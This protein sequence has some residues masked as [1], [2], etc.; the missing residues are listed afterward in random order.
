MNHTLQLLL[1]LNHGFDPP[2]QSPKQAEPDPRGPTTRIPQNAKSQGTEKYDQ[3]PATPK[4]LD[5]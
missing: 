5:M 2:P 3:W 4:A 1:P